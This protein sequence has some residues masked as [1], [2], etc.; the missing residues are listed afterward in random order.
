MAAVRVIRR[1]MNQ[2]AMHTTTPY[3]N[4]P[5][6]ADRRPSG[7]EGG[8]AFNDPFFNSQRDSTR[9]EIDDQLVFEPDARLIQSLEREPRQLTAVAANG[10]GEMWIE[11]FPD[12]TREANVIADFIDKQINTH[13]RNP[14]EI[15]VLAQRRS[16]GNP[17]HA[18]LQ[19]LGVPSKS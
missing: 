14:G 16:I 4:V 10:P 2:P 1:G 3:S 18:A 8:S 5:A 15:L 17:I 11:Q 6:G 9:L 12:V 19:A 7:V 13:G